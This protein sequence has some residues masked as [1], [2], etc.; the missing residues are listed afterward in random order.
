MS[1]A[2]Y[3]GK[4]PE[5]AIRRAMSAV[6]ARRQFWVSG[7]LAILLLAALASWAASY[8]VDPFAP[9]GERPAPLR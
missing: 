7:M 6:D 2:H 9:G 1:V 5:K 3:F 4:S 8:A